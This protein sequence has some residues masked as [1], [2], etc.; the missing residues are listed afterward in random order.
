[1]GVID[2]YNGKNVLLTGTTGFLGKVMLEKFLRVIP[3]VGCLY[4]LIRKKKGLNTMERFKKEVLGSRCFDRVRA[5]NPTFDEY[6]SKK[7]RPIAGDLLKDGLGLSPEDYK[8]LTENLHV[9]INC[10]ASVDFNATLKDAID[11]NVY[12]TLRMFDLAKNVRNLESF[13]HVST[14]YV[15]ADKLGFIEEKVYDLSI[16]PEKMINEQYNLS[17]EQQLAETPRILGNFPN[18]YTYTKSM[19][20][21]IL[22]KRRGDMSLTILRPSIVGSSWRDPNI[23]WIDTVSAA[24]AVYLLGGIGVIKFLE[25]DVNIVFDQVP[26]DFVADE[27]I[28]GAAAFAN[29][30][31]FTIVHTTSSQ[32]NPLRGGDGFNIVMSYWRAHPP[33]KRVGPCSVYPIK[34]PRIYKVAELMQSLPTTAYYKV[35]HTLGNNTMRKKADKLNKIMIRTKTVSSL[36]KHF[37]TKE[38]VYETKTVD[39]MIS[40]CTPEEN[41]EFFL[42]IAEVDWKKYFQYFAWGLH[43]HILGE[44]VAHPTNDSESMDLLASLKNKNYFQDMKWALN[45]GFEFK[46]RSKSEMK[47]FILS[48][49]NLRLV[50]KDLVQNRKNKNINEEKYTQQLLWKASQISNDLISSYSMPMIKLTAYITNFILRNMYEKIV[51]DEKALA[52]L[53]QLE[54]DAKG[55]IVLLPSHRSFVD[56]VLLSYI[57]FSYKMKVPHVGAYDEFLQMAFFP[58]LMRACGAFFMRKPAVDQGE[59]EIYN[60]I[61]TEYLQ[62]LMLED[63]WL[64]LFLEGTRS[65]YGK[66]LAPN[67]NL[68][69]IVTDLYYDK[70]VPDIQLVPVT[71]NYDRVVEGDTFPF[72]LLGEEKLKMKLTKLLISYKQLSKNFGKVYVR[73]AEPISLKEYSN[74]VVTPQSVLKPFD[75][76]E[77]RREVVNQLGTDLIRV[78]NDNL[79]IMPT[80]IVAS[81]ILMNRK[82]LIEE[83]LVKK[84]EWLIPE[85]LKRGGK[86]TTEFVLVTAKQAVSHLDNLLEKKRDIFHPSYTAKNDFKN[87]ILLSYY[88]NMLGHLFFNEALIACSLVAY[89]FELAWKD[90]VPIERLW[91]STGFLQKLI[92]KEWFT[93]KPLNQENFN[94][95][96]STM[97]Q[98]ETFVQ[99]GDK[100]KVAKKG[101][102]LIKFLCYLLWPFIESY[103]VTSVFLFALKGREHATP[104]EKFTSE[105][106][107]FAESMYDERILQFYES[108]S[109]DTIKNALCVYREWGIIETETRFDDYAKA[110]VRFVNLRAEENDL[111]ETAD[112][113]QKFLK[114]SIATTKELPIDIARRN[115][116][117]DYPFMSKL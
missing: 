96:L 98:R 76:K 65:R 86:V 68:L 58:R 3:N 41:R 74:R 103:W 30:R 61:L 80:S 85:I 64:E 38:W 28:V 55:P 20:E 53:I 91:E 35:A 37:A 5:Q 71:L 114:T 78:I 52:K 69:S 6:V 45:H 100:I 83:T 87:I 70:K 63:S 49:P 43:Y 47:A 21:R 48:S 8:E 32:R 77:N 27:M 88:R 95:L 22:K 109:L 13:L 89:G 57:M 115:V 59:K 34:D 51:V 107:G 39:E 90:G 9:M 23:G 105:I 73:F 7:I 4:I 102:E 81:I 108:C 111:K 94:A 50:I 18:T 106:Q 82:G 11:I 116:L 84:T 92:G 16:D 29:K 113:I 75:N 24:S 67:S 17:P 54:K 15:N 104:Y 62:K 60:V 79:V 72:E 36:F 31:R 10:A 12:G 40:F 97:I 42:D 25:G 110:D 117:G 44:K 56:F 101:E 19:V 14:A 93:W 1:M 46:T 99:D 112:N 26:V 33:A 2:Y 66:S